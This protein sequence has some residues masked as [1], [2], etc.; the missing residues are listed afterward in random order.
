MDNNISLKEK[1]EMS[2]LQQTVDDLKALLI[3]ADKYNAD[4]R[5]MIRN[6]LKR[7]EAKL[8]AS[9]KERK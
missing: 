9:I 2:Q 4:N 8:E 7:A 1:I 5:E 3:Y 6:D